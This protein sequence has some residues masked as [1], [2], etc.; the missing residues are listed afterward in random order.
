[1]HELVKVLLVARAQVDERLHRLVRVRGHVLALGLLDD[2]NG[3]SSEVGEVGHAVVNVGGFVDA[4]QWLIEDREKIA[5]KLQ[6][7]SL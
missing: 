2:P 6:C 5:E 4:N 1:M 7:D 3:V